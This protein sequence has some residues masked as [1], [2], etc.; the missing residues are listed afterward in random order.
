MTF[1]G[2]VTTKPKDQAKEAKLLKALAVA[3]TKSKARHILFEL[4]ELTEAAYGLPNEG[5]EEMYL[6]LSDDDEEG[7]RTRSLKSCKE[8]AKQALKPMRKVTKKRK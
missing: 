6:G 8:I 5:Y 2:I 3:K 7:T 1:A 4:T